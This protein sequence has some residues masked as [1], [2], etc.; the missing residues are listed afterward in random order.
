[1]DNVIDFI[2]INRE[3]YLEELKSFLA[4]PSI[5]ALPQHA[6]DVKRCAD[7]CSDEMRRIGLQNVR[8]VATPGNP[9][10]YGDWLAAP[11]AP[12]ILFYGHYDVQPVDPLELWESPPFEATVRDGEIYARGSADDKGQVFMHFKAVEAHM[13]QNQ[14]LPVNMR[15]VLE[16]EEEVG[17]AN[18]DDFIRAHKDELQADVVVISD[19]PMFA[20]GVP[21]ICYGL[22]GLVYFQINLRGSSTDLHSGSFGGAVVNPAYVLS[23]MI[24]QMKDRGGRIRIPGFY[25]DVVP[26]QEEERKAWASLPF[27]EKKFKKDF[28]VPKL[29]GETGYTTLERTWARPTFEVNGLLSGFTGE[30]AKTVLP[31]V[32]MAKVS[33]RLVPNQHPDKIA[34]LF[35]A[36]VRDIAPKTVELK[37]TRMHGGK[38]WMTAYDNPFVQAAGRAIE[39]GFG[40][41]PVFTREGGSIP[42]VSTF[43]EELGL[44]S[45]LF[46]VGL[47]DENA[48][49]P[50]EKLDV[51]NFHGGIISSAILYEEISKGT[52][53]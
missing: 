51:A 28:G 37:I 49:A 32:A 43:Q 13:K 20:R 44:P 14:R 50:N 34:E 40:Q 41:K 39:K 5:S 25:D 33:M 9:V 24:A 48:H 23:Q 52:R 45:V 7:W 21:S 38:P 42:V 27:N 22:R 2:N 30:G 19:S 35:E 3:R 17:S 4:I 12:T 1:M 29:S 18:L 36:H 15:F 47:P 8:L 31:A 10:V 6:G 26:L 16:G 46:G 53:G 11:G